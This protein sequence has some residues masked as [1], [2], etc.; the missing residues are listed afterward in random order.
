MLSNVNNLSKKK[1]QADLE[2]KLIKS[3]KNEFVS[4]HKRSK[5]SYFIV[6]NKENNANSVKI[7]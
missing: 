3:K 4:F 7:K 2:K 1:I 5:C 6:K